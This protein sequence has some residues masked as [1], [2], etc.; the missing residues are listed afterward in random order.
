M[1]HIIAVL[2]ALLLA[3]SLEARSLGAE[4]QKS[5]VGVPVTYQLPV[6]GS[7]PQTYRVTLAIVDPK[8]PDWIIS[9][10]VNGAV[11]TVTAENGGKFSE[12]WNGLDDNFMPV[13]PGDYAVKGIFMPA[14]KWEV[15]GEYHAITPRFALGISSW[16]PSPDQLKTREPFGGDPVNAPIGDVA[17]GPN[18]IA[19][20]YYTYL[21][22]GLNSPM[23]DLNKPI[24]YDQFIRA[25]NSGGAAGG[26]SVTTDGET[27]WAF[28][29]DG[30][31]KFVY[32]ADG[33]P[34]GYSPGTNRPNSYPPDGW[35]TSMAC[36]HEK[37][38]KPFVYIAQRGK[39]TEPI[40]R[41][42]IESTS[43]FADKVTVHDGEN[44]KVLT[45]L[46]LFHPRALAVYGNAL[47]A[48]HADGNGVAVSS[49]KLAAGIPVGNTWQKVFAVPAQIVPSDL[50]IDSHGRFYLTDPDAN[51][52]YQLD[53]TAKVLL[54]YGR[55]AAQ[56]PGSYDAQTFIAPRKLATWTDSTGN[57]RVLVMEVGGPMRVS[58]WS[59]DGKLLREFTSL[60]TKA[61]DGYTI[62]PEHPEDL[63]ISGQLG[64]LTRFKV[65]YVTG[66][67]AI[68]AV[69][70]DVGTDP[71][72]PGLKKPIFVRTHGHEYLAGAASGR[73]NAFNIYRHDGDRWMFSAS[74]IRH[75]N[76]DR[77]QPD[78]YSIWHD[79][80]GNGRVDEAELT[81]SAV[82]GKIFTAHGQNW[83]E[84]LSFLAIGM[85]GPEVFRLAPES[86]DAHDNP[87][88]TH[89]QTLLTDPIFEARAAGKADA[90]HGGNEL[91]EKY[92]SDWSQT[93][94][95]VE[96]G[97]YVQ[98]RGGKS[99]SANEGP[100][101]KVSRY[102]P[103]G[104]GGYV[105]K[106]RT[107]R[108]AMRRVAQ[109]GE[110]YGGMRIR[111]PINGL[112]SVIDQSRCGV[113][114]Y[115]D[116][117]LYV[118]TL[119]PD[120]HR[121]GPDD[122]GLYSLPGEFFVGS[123]Y[124]NKLNGKIY[125]AMGKYTPVL[126]EAQGWSL[127]DN[128]V[129]PLTELQKIVT[130]SA[131]Q[132]ASPPEIAL[133]VRGGAG[134]AHVAAFS[135]A[136]GGASLDGSMSG[137]EA[138]ESV[139]FQAD[140][141]Q[142]VEV[143][144]LYDPDHLYLRW[145]ARLTS[146]FSP[147]AMEPLERI[148]NHDRLADTLSFYIQGDLQAKSGGAA[149][150]RPGDA[151]FVFGVFKDD[152]G[153]VRPA[154]LGMYPQWPGKGNPQV[155]RT[156]VGQATFAHVGPV[157][158]AELKHVIDADGKGFVLVAAIPR[159]AIPSLQQPFT[160]GFRT[161]VNFSATFSGHNKFWWAN[162]DGAASQETLDEPTEAR[163]YPGSWAP[164]QFH[165]MEGGVVVRNWLICGP[166]GGPGAELFKPDLRG[167]MPGSHKDSKRAAH[168]FCETATYPPDSAA[169]FDLQAVYT[170]D[171]IRG[172]WNDPRQV[173]WKPAIIA[174]LDTRVI[175]GPS[176][177]VWYG[178]TWIH[179]P[180]PTE[181]EFKLQGHPETTLRWFVNGERLA[182]KEV[183]PQGGAA[184]R[185]PVQIK[186]VVLRQGWNRVM[187][188]GY[189]VGYPPFRAGLVVNG[190]EDK[191]WSLSFSATPPLE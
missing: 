79:A 94:G 97:Y 74:I 101:Y 124:P 18:G 62:D 24:G 143:R 178:T 38:G 189:C 129:H 119:F 104:K 95:T 80:N 81:P 44:G 128:P 183:K 30:G 68:D 15:D 121:F 57:D 163:L 144:C 109:D 106:W 99:F 155:Y 13:P 93:D 111:R 175:L 23:I 182:I 184:S 177:Q 153:Q 11:R 42:I 130:I 190:Q 107:G 72:A 64:W 131:S 47:Y 43:E 191:L 61:N 41:R 136:L 179:A 83:G 166:F 69:W 29:T 138:S 145:H 142:T 35:V 71:L 37:G 147:K 51:K 63:Y 162:S 103:D 137:W 187:F 19:V 126:Y 160:G 100:Q 50:K 90:V 115:T 86:F 5:D 33:K 59:A 158:G 173:H 14:R 148:F 2:F 139:N 1:K 8:N 165:G 157:A 114:L 76:P 134:A 146:K 53:A 96:G 170:G 48:L 176:A 20:F 21:E 26:D 17:V 135:P 36:L 174:D 171:I 168:D 46:P 6:S 3:M 122:V 49:V 45:D 84:D 133:S 188:R 91:A 140:K 167:E 73:D 82:P 116:D 10:F 127:K 181:V 75:L 120:G 40:K 67:C 98:A 55:L 152:A 9:Q 156:P 186:D 12:P 151:R 180:A 172:Y 105:I 58:E 27:V 161:L 169:R 141:E 110:M 102:I 34:F 87:V 159:A 39:F 7:L 78:T 112:V 185:H 132:I 125:V 123:L 70:P 88:F 89:W 154:A 66:K 56:K 150:G 32:R 4:A 54:T 92:S 22:N 118:D 85:G 149:E 77:R 113:L 60:Q 25:Y 31:P 108:T 65:D 16:L 117:G 164:A 28:S 52:V